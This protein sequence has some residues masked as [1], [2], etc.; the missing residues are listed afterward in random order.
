MKPVYTTTAAPV[1]STAIASIYN[2]AASSVKVPLVGTEKYV[3]PYATFTGAA[4]REMVTLC[5]VLGAVA[6]VLFL[7]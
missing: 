5:G 2:T 1:T 6:F 7:M 4:G 3:A